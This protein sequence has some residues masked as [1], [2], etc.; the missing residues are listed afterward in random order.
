[1]AE[2]ILIK[3]SV[4]SLIKKNY[5]VSFSDHESSGIDKF[6]VNFNKN[7]SKYID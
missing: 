2:I 6:I 4:D 5:F 1:M 7:Y 3:H